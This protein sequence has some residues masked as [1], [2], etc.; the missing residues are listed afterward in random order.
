[1]S[2]TSAIHMSSS[3]KCSSR[4]CRGNRDMQSAAVLFTPGMYW[5]LKLYSN[6]RVD[7]L[8]ILWLVQ[9]LAKPFVVRILVYW[10][11]VSSY[12]EFSAPYE[13]T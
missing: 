1:M 2:D 10:F 5:M 3:V 11:M 6:S 9:S 7:H 8:L 13:C 4:D 12:G